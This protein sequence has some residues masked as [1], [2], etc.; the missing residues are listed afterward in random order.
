M[1]PTGSKTRKGS[2]GACS[3]CG[4]M[5]KKGRKRGDSCKGHAVRTK[6]TSVAV[7]IEQTLQKRKQA[8]PTG[9]LA[10]R[11]AKLFQEAVARQRAYEKRTIEQQL[12][13]INKRPGNSA[14]ERARLAA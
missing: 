7:K 3:Y 8:R 6:T 9:K 4:K 5:H 1:G 14:K 2:R 13:L 12:A 10:A 11:R